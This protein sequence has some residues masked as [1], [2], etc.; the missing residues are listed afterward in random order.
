M[1]FNLTKEQKMLEDT[2]HNFA[3]KEIRPASIE[4][5]R[6]LKP[7]ERILRKE[8]DLA[9]SA[10]GLGL[11]MAFIPAQYGGADYGLHE[12]VLIAEELAWGDLGFL[13]SV[14][15]NMHSVPAI[16]NQG[17]E[18]QKRRWLPAIAGGDSPGMLVGAALTEP[19]TGSNI[20]STEPESGIQTTARLDGR[21]YVLNGQ[22]C[23][24]NNAG[25]ADLYLVWARTSQNKSAAKGGISVFLVPADTPGLKI[26]KTEDFMGIRTSCQGEVVFEDCCVPVENLLGVKGNGM[27]AALDTL[28]VVM[29]LMGSASVGV[30]QAAFENA[31]TIGIERDLTFVRKRLI[32][33]VDS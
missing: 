25:L 3:E 2:V 21:Q 20:F 12:Q 23:F 28:P 31:K 14:M 8:L 17:T 26:G 19:N 30:S 4:C 29:T 7:E 32:G 6:K 22:K 33:C 27:Q 15:G 13:Y 24:I 18:E 9:L 16:I 1:D 5:D 11:G 10:R